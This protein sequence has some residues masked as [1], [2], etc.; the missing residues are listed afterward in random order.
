MVKIESPENTFVKIA[1]HSS[2]PS[3]PSR[4]AAPTPGKG[5]D[6]QASICTEED[7]QATAWGARVKSL[8]E[9]VSK[10]DSLSMQVTPEKIERNRQVSQ[11]FF[12]L[13]MELDKMLNRQGPPSGANWA[14]W[15]SHASERAGA[16]L[17]GES[18]VFGITGP[19]RNYLH[20]ANGIAMGD[21][22]LPVSR[23]LETFKNDSAP[24]TAKLA[25]FLES[26]PDEALRQVFR[27][28]YDAM[29]ET[30]PQQKQE[31][32]LLG[33]IAYGG[34]EQAR[35]DPFLN[36]ALEELPG[37]NWLMSACVGAFAALTGAG[38]TQA[39]LTDK[40][41]MRWPGFEANLNQDVP[42]SHNPEN[43]EAN[44]V[45]DFHR[46]ENRELK[47]ILTLWRQTG[48]NPHAD[49]NAMEGTGAEYWGAL[50]ERMHFIAEM[51]REHLLDPNLFV[52]PS[53]YAQL[54]PG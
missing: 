25:M 50:P 30:D 54:K 46:L 15:A 45:R 35:L 48:G 39:F 41:R 18:Q 14:I 6:D 53:Q 20:Q 7:L 38:N 3:A 36:K 1:T 13:G 10:E 29:W 21:I 8:R 49:P 28:Y 23:F 37:P 22:G 42:P 33:N 9:M 19:G 51:C 40:L 24:D 52:A 11:L 32:V 4:A 17:R 12:D 43:L 27:S 26:L 5:P 34:R 44:K 47:T 31:L 2:V 16:F